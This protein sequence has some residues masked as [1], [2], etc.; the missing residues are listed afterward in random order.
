VHAPIGG[1]EFAEPVTYWA[2]TSVAPSNV[3]V[4]DG[5]GF[6]E[7]RGQ[8]FIGSLAGQR[9]WRV[10]VSGG[11]FASCEAM[12]GALNKRIRD[13]RQGPD[14]WLYVATDDGE[15]HRVER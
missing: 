14:G 11:R 6:P 13:V 9:L 4:Y 10:V 15:I 7:W 12:L 3:V 2:P 5:A 8:L 1:V